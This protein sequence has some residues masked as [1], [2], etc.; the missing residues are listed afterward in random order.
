MADDASV[1]SK[2]DSSHVSDVEIAEQCPTALSIVNQTA[3]NTIPA[4]STARET[5]QSLDP[6]KAATGTNLLK[7]I[8]SLKAEQKELRAKKKKISQTLRNAE[9]RRS[10]LRKK[11]KLL[12]DADLVD[13]LRMRAS[14]PPV[15]SG[16][17]E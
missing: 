4:V 10:R 6:V 1:A 12:S 3:A 13:V 9:R 14:N 7:Q 5:A 8:A 2:H 11:A 17:E 15:Q 16:S